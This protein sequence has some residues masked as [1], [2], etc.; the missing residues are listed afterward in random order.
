MKRIFYTVG[1]MGISSG[2]YKVFH[3]S[4]TRE[5]AEEFTKDNLLE[6]T[7]NKIIIKKQN[8]RW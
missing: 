1:V 6:D 7:P 3:L 5:E 4:K 8:V 2:E